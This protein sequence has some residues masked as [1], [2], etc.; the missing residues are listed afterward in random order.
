[1]L[2]VSMTT[3][4]SFFFHHSTCQTIFH[5][6]K[7]GVVHYLHHAQ[8]FELLSVT[9]DKD[10]QHHCDD[11]S[12]HW[13]AIRKAL[14]H[15]SLE[16]V[17]RPPPAKAAPATEDKKPEEKAEEKAEED[18]RGV[19]K[20]MDE[21]NKASEMDDDDDQMMKEENEGALA[22]ETLHFVDV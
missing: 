5:N 19:M 6:T 8:V 12:P 7:Q 4:N 9:N 11:C 17:F 1:M 3:P 13:M 15:F 10:Q 21:I 22:A 2:V 14:T 18:T 20:F 16:V